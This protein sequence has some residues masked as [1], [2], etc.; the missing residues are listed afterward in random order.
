MKFQK[1]S[2]ILIGLAWSDDDTKVNQAMAHNIAEALK[3]EPS[4]YAVVQT[5]IAKYM[6]EVD[7]AR[8]IPVGP[9]I[10]A[11]DNADSSYLGARDVIL[12]AVYSIGA[13]GAKIA[14]V[15]AHEAMH[16]RITVMLDFFEFDNLKNG[17]R[18]VGDYFGFDPNSPQSWTRNQAAFDAHEHKILIDWRQNGEGYVRT[19]PKMA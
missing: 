11:D 3:A 1:Y 9:Q 2:H 15:Y 16:H 10:N 7:A 13:Y 18:F 17:W 19:V 8:V 12:A 6:P 4:A 5:D 14:S